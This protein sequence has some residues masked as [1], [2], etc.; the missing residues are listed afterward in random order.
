MLEA[1]P[2]APFPFLGRFGKVDI[3]LY[4][5]G[6]RADTIWLDGFSR[7]G[8]RTLTVVNPLGRMYTEVPIRELS[9][10]VAKMAGEA[11]ADVRSA[12]PTPVPPVQGTV[13]GIPATRHRL[14]Y[15]EQAWIDIWTTAAIPENPQWRA[16]VDQ[17]VSS[18]SPDSAKA[19]RA[20]SGTA[21]YV[22]LN[23]RRFR[24]LPLLRMK[25]LS[26]E[27]AGE[28]SALKVGSVYF[29]APLLEAIWK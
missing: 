14:Q 11:T 22:E 17:F 7:T 20:I 5:G 21:L 29:R 12:V 24:K 10:V 28:D 1:N 16:I 25:S 18:I 8:S 15:G 23:F 27:N 3:H 9:D 4:A 26:F 2:A 19:A 6:V 13:R